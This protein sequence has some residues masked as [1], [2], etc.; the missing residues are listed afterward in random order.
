MLVQKLNA[1]FLQ[2]FEGQIGAVEFSQESHR[3]GYRKMGVAG[4]RGIP[5]RMDGD[6]GGSLVRQRRTHDK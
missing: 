5:F 6:G 4:C 3:V 1:T 2:Q